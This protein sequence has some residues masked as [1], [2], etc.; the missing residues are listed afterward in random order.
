MMRQAAR[1]IEIAVV[2]GVLASVRL[3]AAQTLLVHVINDA[4]VSRSELTE[5]KKEASQIYERSG[6]HTTWVDGD[7]TTADGDGAMHLTIVVLAQSVSASVPHHTLGCAPNS[8]R[9]YVYRD[10]VGAFA[11]TYA[12]NVGVLLGKVMAHEVGHLLLPGQGHS[13]EGIMN[14]EPN[15]KVRA[16][17]F[18]SA[19]SETIRARVAAA[20]LRTAI[21]ESDN[22][23]DARSS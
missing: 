7:A 13:T 17:R 14:A 12:L 20:S 3:A 5:A 16:I 6:M 21:E 18:T 9:A 4:Q 2:A 23:L 15:F 11:R 10:R 19:Q 8:T 22:R 1:V